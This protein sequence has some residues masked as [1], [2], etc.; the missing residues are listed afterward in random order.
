MKNHPCDAHTHTHTHKHTHTNTHTDNAGG[1]DGQ[2][3][4]VA[5]GNG[6]R[7]RYHAVRVLVYL[8]ELDMGGT[9][10]FE[11]TGGRGSNM[12]Q[13]HIRAGCNGIIRA[14]IILE[15]LVVS[16]CIPVASSSPG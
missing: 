3:E 5:I 8:G 9:S 13:H 6:P 16:M 4:G 11:P 12:A 2:A 1:F 15:G 14:G 10:L 7:P